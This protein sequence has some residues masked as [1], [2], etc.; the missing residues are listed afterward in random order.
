M[1]SLPEIWD[2]M[3]ENMQILITIQYGD[4]IRV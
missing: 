1:V 2:K 4:Q 3:A